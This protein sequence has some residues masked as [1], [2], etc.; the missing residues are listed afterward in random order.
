MTEANN[1][2]FSSRSYTQSKYGDESQ[3]AFEP[4][5]EKEREIGKGDIEEKLKLL[6]QIQTSII[7][8]NEAINTIYGFRKLTY[9]DYTASGTFTT[10]HQILMRN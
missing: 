8:E 3:I 5:K 7:G 1:T 4:I 6:K 9:A 10:S 2:K